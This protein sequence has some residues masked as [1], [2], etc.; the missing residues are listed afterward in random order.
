MQNDLRTAIDA[1]KGAGDVLLSYFKSDYEIQDKG[2]MNPVTTADFAANDYLE[3]HL[4][5]AQP[6]YGWL[7]EETTDSDARLERERLWVVDPL[8]GT[9]EFIEGVPQFV[10]SIALAE[11]GRPILG[12]LYNPVT[13]ELFTG[14]KGEP[15][16][17]NGTPVTAS[18]VGQMADAEILNSRTETK[19]GLWQNYDAHFKT[20]TPVGS[21]AYKLGLVAAGMSDMFATLRPK[22]E[23]DVC[24]GDIILECAGAAMVKVSG[25]QVQYNNRDVIIRPGLVAGNAQLIN[26]FQELYAK[27][28]A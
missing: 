16:M 2:F 23:W 21:V 11:H 20:L 3:A 7:S 25:E 10:V 19:R 1:A 22:S 6:E 12:V 13:K 8:D 17:L 9:K 14:Y 18:L 28:S 15:A 24:A 27:N 4:R 26:Q 5:D